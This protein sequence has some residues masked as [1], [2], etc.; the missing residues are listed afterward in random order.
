MTPV[1]ARA[2]F[3]VEDYEMTT[4]REATGLR[5][6]DAAKGARVAPAGTWVWVLLAE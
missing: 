4:D 1:K 2:S 6:G 5:A 3:V